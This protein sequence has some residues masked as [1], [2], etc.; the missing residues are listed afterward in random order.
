[1]SS[2][3]LDIS[4]RSLLEHRDM[5]AVSTFNSSLA[6][7]KHPD[8]KPPSLAKHLRVNTAEWRDSS[9]PSA[10]P[11]FSDSFCCAYYEQYAPHPYN[12]AFHYLHAL[13]SGEAARTPYYLPAGIRQKRKRN[14]ARF[15]WF[16]RSLWCG[17]DCS[18]VVVPV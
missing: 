3:S 13:T 11:L 15:G 10:L 6:D 12:S 2:G 7:R 4:T 5:T 1:M 8:M 9:T 17:A 14:K 16:C 18:A